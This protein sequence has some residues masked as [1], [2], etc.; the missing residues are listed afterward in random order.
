MNTNQTIIRWNIYKLE[1]VYMLLFLV[2]IF[3]S[4]AWGQPVLD[5]CSHVPFIRNVL[6]NEGGH[7][8]VGDIN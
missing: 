2:M 8:Q 5:T 7:T 4:I 1:V 3:G 6:G